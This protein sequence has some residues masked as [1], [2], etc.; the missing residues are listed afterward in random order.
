MLQPGHVQQLWHL[1]LLCGMDAVN[2][3]IYSG[4]TISTICGIGR[5]AF[6]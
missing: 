4:W 1:T 2:D 3:E 6:I 5:R